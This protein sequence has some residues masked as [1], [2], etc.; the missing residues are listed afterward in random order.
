M[1]SRAFTPD[2]DI[3][4]IY[5]L[6]DD[7]TSSASDWVALVP[8]PSNSVSTTST[9]SSTELWT[10]EMAETAVWRETAPQASTNKDFPYLRR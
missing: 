10:P 7:V 6:G 2:D 4:V 5:E 1:L 8:A 9:S 3:F